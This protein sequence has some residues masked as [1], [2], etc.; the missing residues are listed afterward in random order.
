MCNSEKSSNFAIIMKFFVRSRLAKWL[1]V[2]CLVAVFSCFAIL[3]FG[4]SGLEEPES[5]SKGRLSV[6][7]LGDSN[8]WIGGDDCGNPSSWSGHLVRLGGFRRSRSFARSGATITNTAATRADTVHY[9]ELLNDTNT[10]YNQALRLNG[11]V[12]RGELENP[13]II[14]VSG[15]SNDAWFQ[16]WR[17]GLFDDPQIEVT[18]FTSPAEATTLKSSLLLV[19]RLLRSVNPDSRIVVVG[20]PFMTKASPEAISKVNDEMERVA[21][22][23][24]VVMVRLDRSE[25]I[26][27]EVE[28]EKFTFTTDGV[29]TSPG[30]AERIAA[31]VWCLLNLE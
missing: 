13:D 22:D 7:F 14:I 11:T 3:V 17:P 15:G 18:E 6:A 26:D 8:I 25:L 4:S 19:I 5:G 12:R 23:E 27:P 28:S 16:S 21:N 10:L 20:P 24:G 9:S 1:R 29:H 30:G 2:C 31:Y